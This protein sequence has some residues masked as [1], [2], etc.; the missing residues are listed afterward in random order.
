MAMV[1]SGIATFVLQDRIVEYAG[2]SWMRAIEPWDV[3]VYMCL[4]I[5]AASFGYVAVRRVIEVALLRREMSGPVCPKCK[6]SLIGLRVETR[7]VE[8][9]PAQNRVRCPE[10][11]RNWKM[12]DIGVT[13]RDLMPREFGI[14]QAGTRLPLRG[15]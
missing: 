14:A 10:C 7:G 9:D 13:P 15:E 3:I 12:L 1:A 6:S 4:P 2:A 8:P 11:G 5:L